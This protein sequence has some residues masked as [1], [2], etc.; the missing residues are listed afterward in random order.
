MLDSTF[1][2]ALDPAL[3]S[4]WYPVSDRL[5]PNGVRAVRLLGRD[6]VLWQSGDRILAWD[7]RCP[8]RGAQL[9]GGTVEGDRLICPYHGLH[10][11]PTGRCT[12]VPAAP[13]WQPSDRLHCQS[14]AACWRYGLLWVSFDPN[15]DP[16]RIPQ[17]SEWDDPNYRRFLCGAYSVRSSPWRVMENFLDVSHFPF[18]HGGLLGDRQ[19]AAIPDYRT[20]Q[21]DSGLHLQNV[22]VH[23]P[24][25]DGT[26]VGSTV[27]YNYHATTPW[28]ADFEKLSPAGRL[29]IYFAICPQDAETCLGWMWVAMNYGTDIPE[30]QL[31]AFQ[32]RVVRQDIPIVES[33]RPRR[34]PLDLSADGHLPSDRSSIAYRQWLC[35]LG[36]QFGAIASTAPQPT[37]RKSLKRRMTP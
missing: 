22:R 3:K 33:Q 5:E 15:A 24:D 4:Q 30:T 14:Y 20:H 8:H 7:D 21:D 34:L 37:P 9:S 12:K 36:I 35:R 16:S 31:R 23:Q 28:V 32:D 17:F 25:P 1:D 29:T 19:H 13:N 11:D 10:F 27:T 6:L 2:P 18:V 26:G